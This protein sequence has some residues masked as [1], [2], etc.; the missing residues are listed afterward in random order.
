M[1][2]P[3]PCC[4]Q[5]ACT[6]VFTDDFSGSTV[7][8]DWDD[9]ADLTIDTVNNSA[10]L[11]AGTTITVVPTLPNGSGFLGFDF[12]MGAKGDRF[13]VR[14]NIVD[15]NNHWRCEF[16]YDDDPCTPP[17]PVPPLIDTVFQELWEVVGGVDEYRGTRHAGCPEYEPTCTDEFHSAEMCW[18]EGGRLSVTALASQI[19]PNNFTG[20]NT[21]EFEAAVGDVVL[22]NVRFCGHV[23]VASSE[24]PCEESQCMTCGEGE[25][26]DTIQIEVMSGPDTG[27]IFIADRYLD[28]PF[29]VGFPCSSAGG[30]GYW[31]YNSPIAAIF[32]PDVLYTLLFCSSTTQATFTVQNHR[33]SSFGNG[34]ESFDFSDCTGPWDVT[35][36]TGAGETDYR[37]TPL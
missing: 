30:M 8:S 12:K 10:T 3:N 2:L 14:F 18:Y 29:D 5:G 22:K 19:W 26:G 32:G 9:A 20:G 27:V 16:Y 24:C 33:Y 28:W 36:G 11:P 1:T 31:R 17:F 25:F 4:C 37:I 21:F 34:T 15:A 35:V 6:C 13:I 7:N 23:N